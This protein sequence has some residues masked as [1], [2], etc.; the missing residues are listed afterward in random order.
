MN[1]SIATTEP[2][3]RGATGWLRPAAGSAVFLII[4]SAIVVSSG[5]LQPR[6]QAS[7]ESS[8]ESS[9]PP[10]QR[11]N[12]AISRGD[13]AASEAACRELIALDAFDARARFNLGYS[14]HLQK[15][16]DEAAENYNKSK[17]FNEFRLFS[18]YNLACIS[19]LQDKPDEAI[20]FLRTAISEGF[21]S[22]RGIASDADFATL[23]GDP[24]FHRLVMQER[25]NRDQKELGNRK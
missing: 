22:R 1:E 4:L 9:R 20:E 21:F 16:L 3:V 7:G 12:A 10:D 13:W 18:L 15:K 24:E 5:I 17:N 14:L 23:S 25:I 8:K 19:A 11:L 2:A 6:A